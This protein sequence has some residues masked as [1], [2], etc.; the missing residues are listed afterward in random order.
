MGRVYG[1]YFL[2]FFRVVLMGEGV[3]RGIL[4]FQ[5]VLGE[6]KESIGLDVGGFLFLGFGGF[7]RCI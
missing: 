1:D 4:V 5:G 3:G 6:W 7:Q 2:L